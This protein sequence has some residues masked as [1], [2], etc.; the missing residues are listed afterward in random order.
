MLKLDDFKLE[1]EFGEG[2]VKNST[3]EWEAADRSKDVD[4]WMGACPGAFYS[5]RE[6]LSCEKI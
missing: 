1:T 3:Y 6:L 5:L 4:V 2:Y